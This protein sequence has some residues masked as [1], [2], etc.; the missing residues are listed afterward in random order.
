MRRVS[1]ASLFTRRCET[2]TSTRGRGLVT[3]AA[4][5]TTRRVVLQ[6][7]YDGGGYNGWEKKPGTDTRTVQGLLE[8]AAHSA[9]GRGAADFTFPVQVRALSLSG[10]LPGTRIVHCDPTE[11]VAPSSDDC[12]RRSPSRRPVVDVRVESLESRPKASARLDLEVSA[13]WV[14]PSYRGCAVAT[15]FLF[16]FPRRN[17]K[18]SSV[19]LAGLEPH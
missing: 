11:W 5:E 12:R 15:L 19:F 7:Q 10:T 13:G 16:L 4:A 14:R 18:T 3:L 9:F 8:H 1:L 6:V 2:L 17:P